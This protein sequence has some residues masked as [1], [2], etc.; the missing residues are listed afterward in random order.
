MR[1]A[2]FVWVAGVAVAEECR[3]TA[4]EAGVVILELNDTMNS[5]LKSLL[6]WMALVSSSARHLAVFAT[7][8]SSATDIPFTAV[9]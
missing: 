5:T 6:F 4:P 9:P 8:Q 7:M 1:R 2:A 3:V